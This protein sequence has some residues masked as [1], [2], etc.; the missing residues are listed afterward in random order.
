VFRTAN[1]KIGA[2]KIKQYVA[3]GDNSYIICDIK[4]QKD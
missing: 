1:G 4:V 2:I 3:A